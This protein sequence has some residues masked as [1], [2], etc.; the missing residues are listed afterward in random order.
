MLKLYKKKKRFHYI[1]NHDF[2]FLSLHI[3]VCRETLLD[4]I[5]NLHCSEEDSKHVELMILMQSIKNKGQSISTSWSTL[6]AVLSQIIE[7]V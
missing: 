5:I 6:T 7:K 2:C 3:I 1:L 4:E